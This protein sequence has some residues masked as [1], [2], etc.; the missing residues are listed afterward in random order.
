[1]TTILVIDDDA[2]IRRLFS[3][4]LQKKGFT[5]LTAGDAEEGLTL[6]NLHQVDLI[7]CDVIMPGMNGYEFLN[8]V[9]IDSRFSKI[10]VIFLSATGSKE[11]VAT[12]THHQAARVLKK[13]CMP[14]DLE[15]VITE[16][17]NE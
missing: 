12:V 6:L 11:D 14:Q 7:T 15:M 5:V 1:M 13:P 17:I 9:K 10:P 3:I 16:L 8:E 2:I 4:Y